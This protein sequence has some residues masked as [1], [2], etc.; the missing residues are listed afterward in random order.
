[1]PVPRRV[2]RHTMALSAHQHV[3][4]PVVIGRAAHLA[5]LDAHLHAARDGQGRTILLA[6]EA[7]IGKSRLVAEA[8]ASAHAHGMLA[9]EG[10]CFEPDRSVPYAPLLALLR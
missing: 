8:R 2:E 3:R 4:S 9:L 1:M 10:G 5:A 7:G 6:G